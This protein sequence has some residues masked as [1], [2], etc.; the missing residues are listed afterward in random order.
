RS[1][2]SGAARGERPRRRSRETAETIKRGARGGRGEFFQEDKKTR[3]NSAGPASSALKSFPCPPWRSATSVSSASRFVSAPF[4]WELGLARDHDFRGFDD[5]HCLIPA[6]QLQL[7][8][9]VTGNHRGQRLIANPEP[10]LTEQ[11]VDAHF[12]DE[13][14]QPIAA[15]ERHDQTARSWL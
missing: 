11:S 15:A 7:V 13:A 14:A 10:H 12:L 2:H 5:G 6:A 8:N 4:T 1:A 3:K 9:G